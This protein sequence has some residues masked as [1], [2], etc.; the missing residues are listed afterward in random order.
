MSQNAPIKFK[1]TPSGYGLATILLHWIS[2]LAIIFLFA[3]GLYMTGLSYYDEWYHK[4]PALHVSIGLLL[5]FLFLLRLVWRMLNPSPAPLTANRGAVIAAALVKGLL[6]VAAFALFTTGYLI[7][8]AEG[9]AASI[10]DSIFIPAL[11]EFDSESV[12]LAGEIHEFLAWTIVIMALLHAGAALFHH[13][14]LRDRTLVRILK[15]VKKTR[16]SL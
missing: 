3:L 15:P 10:F 5:F 4:G 13:F 7:V 1:D 6:Y 16:E 14:V 12:D 11:R 9:Q 8:T 2:A